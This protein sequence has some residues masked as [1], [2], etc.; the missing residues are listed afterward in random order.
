M[1]ILLVHAA[2]SEGEGLNSDRHAFLCCGVGKAAAAASLQRELLRTPA[3]RVLIFG[4]CGAYP[5]RHYRR[6]PALRPGDLCMVAEDFLADEG[7]G[8][9]LG[10][11]DM[12]SMQLG[13]IGP[14]QADPNWT[15]QLTSS[16]G[17]PSL[18][19]ATVSTCSGSE[20]RSQE[21]AAR[22]GAA[23]ESMEGAALAMVC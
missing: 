20:A 6:G 3:E 11:R 12:Q 19:A 2:E 15:E 14:F 8:L 13:E 16:L 18:R 22:T 23:V 9:E 4:I 10:F 17:I 7:V 5:E 21:L 1:S